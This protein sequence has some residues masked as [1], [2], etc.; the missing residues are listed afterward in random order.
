MDQDKAEA[1][2]TPLSHSLQEDKEPDH[3]DDL[4]HASTLEHEEETPGD[5]TQAPQLAPGTLSENDFVQ[6]YSELFGMVASGSRLKSLEID[7]ED[8]QALRAMY[9]RACK[10]R[11][12]Q[13]M[14][15]PGG[16]DLMDWLLI[17]NFV[18]KKGASVGAE[19]RAKAEAK[20]AKA[21]P[22][23][24]Q[25]EEQPLNFEQAKQAAYEGPQGSYPD[26]GQ[27]AALTS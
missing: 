4:I 13:W 20:K 12:L 26:E 8:E 5:M 25:E 24:R 23:P 3:F 21:K 27:R 16:P 17:G 6:M 11:Y 7:E 22:Q 19:I 14:L 2:K 9:R 18:F 1:S 10:S 15:T